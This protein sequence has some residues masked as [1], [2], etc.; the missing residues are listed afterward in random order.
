MYHRILKAGVLCA[1][2]SLLLLPIVPRFAAA[3]GDTTSTSTST[4]ADVVSLY[5]PLGTD[6]ESYDVRYIIGRVIRGILSIIGSIA[7]LMFIYGGV[8]WMTSNGSPERV[9]KGRDILVWAVAGLG[10]IF[11]S[12]AIVNAILNALTEGSASGSDSTATVQ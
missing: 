11:S 6:A 3:S 8:L 5:N 9:K 7:L 1:Y 12:Y 2:L 4:S 10:L